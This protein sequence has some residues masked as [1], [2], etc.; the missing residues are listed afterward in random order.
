MGYYTDY[1]L[2]VVDENNNNVYEPIE[3]LLEL[4]EDAKY[5]LYNDGETKDRC[6]WYDAQPD[7]LEF[8]K[9]YPD[10]L[11]VLSGSGDENGDLWK[12]YAKNGKGY[13]QEAVIMFPEFDVE[14]MK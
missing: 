4:N 8:S 13:Y 6:K 5:A 11:F 7:V 3:V 1:E 12:Y 14:K 9:K 10:L 2:Q